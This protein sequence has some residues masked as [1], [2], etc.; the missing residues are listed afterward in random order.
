MKK[1]M[2]LFLAAILAPGLV[3][4]TEGNEGGHGGDDV[5]L[6]FVESFRIAVR[7]MEHSQAALYREL[8]GTRLREALRNATI[9]ATDEDLEVSVEGHRQQTVAKNFF[10]TRLVLVN[11]ARWAAIRDPHL[12]E[13][14]ALHE[15]LGL[16]GLERSGFYEYSSRYLSARNQ[17]EQAGGL[18][19]R[20]A[21]GDIYLETTCYGFG[22]TPLVVRLDT[23]G[24][25]FRRF[26][27][28]VALSPDAGVVIGA[29]DIDGSPYL[30]LQLW[31]KGKETL[32][33]RAIGAYI[34][35]TNGD[36]SISCELNY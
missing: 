13:A 20:G 2:A 23:F 28:E 36:T 1:M 14:I 5:A 8:G 30:T 18:P 33:S 12:R 24:E 27:G 16:M 26:K 22:D 17:E 10:D 9:L 15:I 4:G 35:L 11:R 3:L 32:I 31:A 6:E 7:F 29:T 34:S 21:D 19:I 25:S